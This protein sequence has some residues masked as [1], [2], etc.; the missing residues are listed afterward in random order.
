MNRKELLR[1]VIRDRAFV[2]ALV[3]CVFFLLAIIVLGIT[4]I[5]PSDL[6]I[7]LRNTVFGI[8]H[9]YREQWYSELSLIGFAVIVA[10]LHTL[11]SARLYTLKDRRYAIAF[12]WLTAILLGIT[13][14]ILLAIFRVIAIVE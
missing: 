7:P 1:Q 3:A 9:T 12:Q 6:Q 2:A 14:V 13:F 11:I 4:Q 5:H 10:V 8:T